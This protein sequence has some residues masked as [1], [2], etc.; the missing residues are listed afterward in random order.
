MT[1]VLI[2]V[3]PKLLINTSKHYHNKRHSIS[4]LFVIHKFSHSPEVVAVFCN[5]R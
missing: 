2:A 1:I 5:I 4:S 3:R